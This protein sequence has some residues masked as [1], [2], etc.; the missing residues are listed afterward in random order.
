VILI[1]GGTLAFFKALGRLVDWLKLKTGRSDYEVTMGIYV[2]LVA[3]IIA[4][5][6]TAA[7]AAGGAQ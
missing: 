6:I 7:V 1:V 4:G 3:L 5:G 2:V